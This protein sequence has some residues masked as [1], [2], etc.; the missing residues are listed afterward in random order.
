MNNKER[1]ALRR[2]ELRLGMEDEIAKK[3]GTRIS[4]EIAD[5]KVLCA[6][7]ADLRARQVFP[8]PNH[9]GA[10]E[11]NKKVLMALALGLALTKCKEATEPEQ[12]DE[13]ESN[14]DER[15]QHEHERE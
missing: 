12:Q 7:V 8:N 15:S 10:E 6:A 3:H 1:E 9:Q 2:T 4:D 14:D 5:Q 13:Q 11:M